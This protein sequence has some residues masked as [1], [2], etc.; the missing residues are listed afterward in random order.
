[1]K[2]TL[3]AAALG[4]SFAMPRAEA[5]LFNFSFSNEDGALAGTVTGTITLP[6]GDGIFAASSVIVD[7]APAALGGYYIGFDFTSFNAPE[8]LFTVTGG[9]IDVANS[10]FVGLFNA[11]TAL[12]L[13]GAS[14]GDISF[15]DA[16]DAQDLGATGVQDADS[17]T[18]SFSAQGG[19]TAVPE[20][21]AAGA[22]LALAW[23]AGVLALVRRKV[24]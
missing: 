1:M 17:S 19:G 23:L 16:L 9:V 3:L 2:K 6:D 14:L 13:H 21:D 15:L 5:A 18:L 7:S 4:L 22:P 20:L 10:G 8:N 11:S 12:A 24:A